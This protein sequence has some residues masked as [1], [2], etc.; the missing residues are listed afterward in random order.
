[1]PITRITVTVV[2]RSPVVYLYTSMWHVGL[3]KNVKTEVPALR[4]YHVFFLQFVFHFG[5]EGVDK[6][7]C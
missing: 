2:N 7:H 6:V 1:M 3:L 4:E 5:G